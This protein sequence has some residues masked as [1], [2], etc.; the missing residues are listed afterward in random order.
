MKL[1]MKKTPTYQI[2]LLDEKYDRTEQ[3]LAATIYTVSDKVPFGMGT[4]LLHCLVL[5]ERA[6]APPCSCVSRCTRFLYGKSNYAYGNL[7]F[8][9]D[10]AYYI[11]CKKMWVVK[12]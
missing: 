11:L 9:L 4:A 2:K 3:T 12:I 5:W 1:S 10:V 7:L 8:E 6:R